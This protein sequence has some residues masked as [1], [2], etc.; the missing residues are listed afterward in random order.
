MEKFQINKE[1]IRDFVIGL[2]RSHDREMEDSMVLF[3][4]DNEGNFV[5]ELQ[6]YDYFELV[7]KYDYIIRLKYQLCPNEWGDL[8]EYT[9]EF[10][11]EIDLSNI[12]TDYITGDED[13]DMYLSFDQDDHLD[14]V[15]VW[16]MCQKQTDKFI[17]CITRQ[18]ELISLSEII[19]KHA[20]KTFKDSAEED[21]WINA[22]ADKISSIIMDVWGEFTGVDVDYTK[23]CYYEMLCEKIGF[24]PE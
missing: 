21:N 15:K 18:Q 20:K 10:Y 22:E 2:S 24:T 13:E 6:D 3:A 16:E 4:C 19:E 14:W 11:L 9:Q 5:R 23:D 17:D 12:S 8:D 1:T 7:E